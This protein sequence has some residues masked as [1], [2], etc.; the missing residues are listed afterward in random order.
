MATGLHN[1]VHI[2]SFI[3]LESLLPS[4]HEL[5]ARHHQSTIHTPANNATFNTHIPR[6]KK[7]PGHGRWK[8]P[9]SI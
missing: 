9:R 8:Q 5:T 3:H 6:D 1:C 7:R 2:R 4:T